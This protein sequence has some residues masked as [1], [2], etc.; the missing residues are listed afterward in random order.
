MPPIVAAAAIAG[1]AA[2]GGSVIQ[3]R[4]A[5][6]AA[7]L[8]SQG[9]DKTL[10]F[11]RE[12][13]ARDQA[14]FD[15]TQKANYDQWA[16]REGRI[17]SLGELLGMAPRQIPGYVPTTAGGPPSVGQATG[18]PQGINFQGEFLKQIQGKPFN[19]QTLLALE[20]WLQ[21]VGSKLTPPNAVGDRTKIFDP[22]TKQWVRV[23]FGEGHPVWIPQG[24]AS[25]PAANG[26][27][28]SIASLFGTPNAAPMTTPR[29]PIT[30]ALTMPYGPRP[31]A[32]YLGA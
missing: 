30:P 12:Q 17:G 28:G 29:V 8:E 32:S 21:S 23:G 19:Q 13:A 11:Q 16:A 14:N 15:A 26:A 25:G 22:T 27:P 7:K 1:G 24:S 10:L 4:A 6:K 2:L 18:A 20:P 31:I 5:G 9:A 3:A